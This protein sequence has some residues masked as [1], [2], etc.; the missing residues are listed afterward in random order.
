VVLPA[1]ARIKLLFGVWFYA[2]LAALHLSLILRLGP[3]LVDLSWRA[4]GATANATALAIFALT[5]VGA[6]LAWRAR[7]G[8]PRH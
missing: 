2:P 4:W 1:V 7:H 5:V 3:G 8:D 6:A